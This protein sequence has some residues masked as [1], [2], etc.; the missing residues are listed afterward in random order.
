MKT[1]MVGLV[2]FSIPG[3]RATPS[4]RKVTEP[5][6]AQSRHGGRWYLAE[7]GH[8]VYCRGPVITVVMG[9]GS[10]RKIATYCQGVHPLVPLK[11]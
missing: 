8:A 1:L 3:F 11:D 2:L 5:V 9:D 6:A 7:N 10:L 4:P